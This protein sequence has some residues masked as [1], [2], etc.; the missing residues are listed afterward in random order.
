[1]SESNR[2]FESK[3]EKYRE[4][5]FIHLHVRNESLDRDSK[6]RNWEMPYRAGHA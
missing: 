2:S 5:I 1:M 4:I 3:K 6:R